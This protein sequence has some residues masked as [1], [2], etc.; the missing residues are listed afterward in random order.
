M[1]KRKKALCLDLDGTVRKSRSGRKFIKDKDDVM[2]YDDMLPKILSDFK[3]RG[4]LIFGV[5]NQGAVAHGIKSITE[6]NAEMEATKNLFPK[7]TFDDIIYAPAKEC[8]S[9]NDYSQKS[10]LRKPYYGM[11]A[12]LEHKFFTEKQTVVLWEGSVMVGDMNSDLHCA[13][14]AGITYLE[15][16]DFLNLFKKNNSKK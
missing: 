7:D 10:L 9:E 5:S 14:S 6:V 8:W 13:R 15:I 3:E 2:L 4:W 11:L 1:F 16:S 12:V